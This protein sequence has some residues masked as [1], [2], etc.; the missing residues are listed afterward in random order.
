MKTPIRGSRYKWEDTI[1]ECEQNFR[2]MTL[3]KFSFYCLLLICNLL[4]LAASITANNAAMAISV[5]NGFVSRH[6]ETLYT[7]N[8]D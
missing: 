3:T 2:S 7:R 4:R 5:S 1:P 6:L 8:S